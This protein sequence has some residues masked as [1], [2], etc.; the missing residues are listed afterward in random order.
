MIASLTV[1]ALSVP[2]L[3]IVTSFMH[4]DEPMKSNVFVVAGGSIAAI[5]STAYFAGFECS[6]LQATPGKILLGLQVTNGRGERIG[7]LR[8]VLRFIMKALSGSLFGLAYLTCL[9]TDNRQT[10][11]D[12]VMNTLVWKVKRETNVAEVAAQ[13]IVE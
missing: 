13:K 1:S 12:V 6:R 8:A 2:I 4:I 7:F 5:V 9:I 10:V 11:H 3:M